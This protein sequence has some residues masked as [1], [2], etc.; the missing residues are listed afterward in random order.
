[1]KTR[2]PGPCAP[3]ASLTVALTPK[4]PCD[5][6]RVVIFPVKPAPCF[7]THHD[8]YPMGHST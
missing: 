4:L 8:G 7:G 2:A 1:M 5:R 3:W 6:F